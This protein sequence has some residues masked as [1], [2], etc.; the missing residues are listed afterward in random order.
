MRHLLTILM[1]FAVLIECSLHISRADDLD[2]SKAI[3]VAIQRDAREIHIFDP[4]FVTVTLENPS[5]KVVNMSTFILGGGIYHFHCYPFTYRFPSVRS[6]GI[7]HEVVIRPREKWL[8]D[9]E[10]LSVPPLDTLQ[11]EIWNDFFTEEGSSGILDQATIRS[12][13]VEVRPGDVRQDEI[14][15]EGATKSLNFVDRPHMEEKLLRGIFEENNRRASLNLDPDEFGGLT[16]TDFPRISRFGVNGFHNYSDL[17]EQLLQSRGSLSP[18]SLR[19]ILNLVELLKN[20]YEGK[21]QEDQIKAGEEVVKYLRSLPEVEQVFLR[22]R[23]IAYAKQCFPLTVSERLVTK[24]AAE[25]P[26]AAFF[27]DDY[28]AYLKN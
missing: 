25:L 14:N 7:D 12:V 21:T 6:Y 13:S 9:Y 24:I 26:K 16:P 28:H 11:H 10:S 27:R 1:T 20:V 5:E 17:T 3:A 18:G 2:H 23:T 19:D 4:L 8:I 15:Y 22:H